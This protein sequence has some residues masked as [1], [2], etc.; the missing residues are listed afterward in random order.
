MKAVLVEDLHFSYDG[1][2][3]FEGAGLAIDEGEFTA[4]IGPNGGGKT[5]LMRICLGLLKPQRGRVEILGLS[6][7]EARTQVGYVPQDLSVSLSFPITVLEVVM[8]GLLSLKRLGE[9]FNSHDRERALEILDA[10]EIRGLA[11]R[12]VGAVSGGQRQRIFVARALVANPKI[13]FLDEPTAAMDPMFQED[14]FQF[15]HR[16]NSSEGTTVVV[17]THDVGAISSHVGSVACVGGKGIFR[18][19]SSAIT[20]EMLEAAYQCPVD[21]IAHGV[22]HRLFREH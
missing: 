19:E 22:P 6:P 13:L 18:H 21:L 14:L 1:E 12:P 10:M 2:P 8:T 9:R 3:V 11:D 15:L 4:V 17:I 7:E 5:T 20:P 16:L